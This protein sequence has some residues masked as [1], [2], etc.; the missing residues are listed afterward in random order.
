MITSVLAPQPTIQIL[1]NLL[2]RDSISETFGNKDGK[3]YCGERKF[4]I[5]KMGNPDRSNV[6]NY[7]EVNNPSLQLQA[8][9]E[10]DV[11]IN[12][13]VTIEVYLVDYDI[14]SINKSV[15]F[16]ITVTDCE[17]TSLEVVTTELQQYFIF[18]PSQ[19]ATISPNPFTITPLCTKGIEYN[20]QLI[21]AD[22]GAKEPLPSFIK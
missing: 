14:S 2:P 20:V 16:D 10:I 6:L 5:T 18:F 8:V 15:N 11:A 4:R 19:P 3:T 17:I 1:T 13:A 22:T 21:N 9:D 7:S 12:V